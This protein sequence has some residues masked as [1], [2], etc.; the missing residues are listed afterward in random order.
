MIKITDM[1]VDERIKN[2]QDIHLK[3][4]TARAIIL[5]DD[6]IL[7]AYSKKFDDYM[8]PGGG[9]EDEPIEQALI[10]EVEEEMGFIIHNIRPIGYIEEL[11]LTENGLNLYQKSHY[12]FSDIEKIG[13]K[14]LETYEANFGLE[15]VWV[16]I[17]EVI[18]QNEYIIDKRRKTPITGVHPFSTLKRENAI[19]KHVL[20]EHLHEKI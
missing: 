8:T 15:A 10:R 18:R 5:K 19:L 14:R 6:Q 17:K 2:K 3:R 1:I 11:R 13:N 7:M 4:F 12:F 16:N 9:I 20:K